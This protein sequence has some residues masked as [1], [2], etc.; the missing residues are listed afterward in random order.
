MVR[1]VVFLVSVCLDAFRAI[2]RSREELVLENLALRQQVAALLR[3]RPRP[4]LDDVDRG[5]WVALLRSWPKWVN[6]LLI[7][8]P[9]TVARWHRERFRR[10]WANLS[11]RPGRPWIGVEI[12]DLIR[13][14]AAHGWGAPRIHGE[15]LKLGFDVS[16]A[17]VSRY[18]PRRPVEPDQVARWIAF[19]RNHKDA[20]AAMDFFTVPTLS[21]RVLY[22]L[23]IIDH[24]RRRIVSFR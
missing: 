14:M 23:F 10:H 11:R 5:F 8:K 6:A 7:V 4:A 20:I 22:G 1:L 17:T 2:R 13:A 19:L 9:D 3:Q 15:L 24:G 21:L 16:E 12:R 18:M